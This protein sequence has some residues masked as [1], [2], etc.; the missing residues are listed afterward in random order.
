MACK[1][2]LTGILACQ[3]G[4]LYPSTNL[5]IAPLLHMHQYSI[6][7]INLKPHLDCVDQPDNSVLSV[8]RV[9]CMG[10]VWSG[11]GA[12]KMLRGRCRLRCGLSN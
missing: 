8:L 9:A 3:P 11:C 2:V 5:Y 1:L 4:Q 7:P 10:V 12:L 6:H